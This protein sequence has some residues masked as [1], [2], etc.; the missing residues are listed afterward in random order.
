MVRGVLL[1]FYGTLVEEDDVNLHAITTAIHGSAQGEV[2]FAEVGQFWYDAFFRLTDAAA[3]ETFR[4]QAAIGRASLDEA[5]G[6]FGSMVDAAESLAVQQRY[7]SGPDIY[8]ETVPFLQAMRDLGLVT[9]IVSNAD[10]ADVDA[11]LALHG[12]EVDHVMTSED[13]RHYKPHPRIFELAME[14]TGLS[15]RDL[16]HVGDSWRS[17]VRGA[18]GV[19]IRPVWINR[20][21]RERPADGHHAHE[22]RNLTTLTAW[23]REQLR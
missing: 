4:S 11:A 9:C 18:A 3:G 20:V 17:D 22:V 15:A 12:L 5:I 6:R 19:G 14:G 2:T 13:A 7:W 16:V 21:G 1:D 8:E 10:R 23:L